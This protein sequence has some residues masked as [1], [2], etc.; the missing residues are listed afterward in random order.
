MGH[1]TRLERAGGTDEV[2]EDGDVGAVDADAAGVDGKAKAFGKIEIHAGIIEFRKAETLRGRNA[3]ESGRIDRTGRPVAAPGAASNFVKFPPVAFL[4][5]SHGDKSLRPSFPFAV[6]P[7]KVVVGHGTTPMLSA[8][9]WKHW[10][11][12]V[13][14]RFTGVTTRHS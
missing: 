7:F 4:P 2:A 5:S 1:P 6:L 3:I 8:A 12:M 14:K 13:P 9:G 11:P 10:M